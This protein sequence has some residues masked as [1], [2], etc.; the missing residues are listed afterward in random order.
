MSQN[1][2]RKRA[3][4]TARATGSK[5]RKRSLDARRA[6]TAEV[7]QQVHAAWLEALRHLGYGPQAVHAAHAQAIGIL[8]GEKPEARLVLTPP[9][10]RLVVPK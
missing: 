10:K 9:E 5:R 6:L 7:A 2:A 8:R 3:R 4:A 1:P